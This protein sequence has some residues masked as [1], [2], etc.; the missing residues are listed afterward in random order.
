[1]FINF[2]PETQFSISEQLENHMVVGHR[3]DNGTRAAH[4]TDVCIT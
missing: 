2:V 1:M 4:D 3:R